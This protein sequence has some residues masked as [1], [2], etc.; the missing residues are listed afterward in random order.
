MRLK[1]ALLQTDPE[2]EEVALNLSVAEAMIDK[3]DASLVVLPEM[4]ATG[5]SMNAEEIAEPAEGGVV[6]EWMRRVA[7]ASGKAITGSVAV[8]EQHGD[9]ETYFNRL[10]FA[11][12]DGTAEY[13]DK[14]HLFRMGVENEVYTPGN[15]RLIV[16]WGGFRIMPVVCYDLRFPVWCRNRGDYDL[17]I[18]VASWPASRSYAWSSLLKARAIENVAYVAAVNRTGMDPLARYSGDSLILNYKGQPLAEGDDSPQILEAELDMEALTDFR[19]KFPVHLDA[20][21]FEI[22]NMLPQ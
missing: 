9:T 13:Y 5:F 10:I 22:P 17:M 2:W 3:T 6:G 20:D 15:K 16:E 19:A 7:A 14:R 4:F 11:K 1:I 12:P 8:R 21:K 18:D